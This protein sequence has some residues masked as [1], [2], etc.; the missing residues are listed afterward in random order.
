MAHAVW[1]SQVQSAL[2]WAKNRYGTDGSTE[3]NWNFLDRYN[4]DKL[5]CSQLTWRIHRQ[6]GRNL[7]SNSWD[8]HLQLIAR[9]GLWIEAILYP[10]ILPDE[11]AASSDVSIFTVGWQ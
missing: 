2:D 6:A 8:V 4:E 5:Y 1:A 3:Y 9:Y 10:A 7:D 11:I